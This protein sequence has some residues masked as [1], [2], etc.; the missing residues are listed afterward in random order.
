MGRAILKKDTLIFAFPP[1]SNRCA[2]ATVAPAGRKMRDSVPEGSQFASQAETI[3]RGRRPLKPLLPAIKRCRID[4][5]D[6][7]CL[8]D[9]PG[10]RQNFANVLV[11]DF[12]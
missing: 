3:F 2:G 12:L 4:L 8:I 11:F 5:E 10:V 1:Q 9:C 7:C 6:L